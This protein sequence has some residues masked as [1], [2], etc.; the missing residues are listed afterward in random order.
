MYTIYILRC[1][2]NKFYVGKTKNLKNR[3]DKHFSSSDVYFLKKYKPLKL[4]EAITNQTSFDEDKYVL[5]YMSKYGIQNVRGGS[6]SSIYL[7]QNQI[8]VLN[9][10]IM[11]AKDQCY[12]CGKQGHFAKDCVINIDSNPIIFRQTHDNIPLIDCPRCIIL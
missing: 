12:K 5:I 7:N 8:Q 6:F 1:Q 9:M 10:M 4:E 11:G 2:S 3:L